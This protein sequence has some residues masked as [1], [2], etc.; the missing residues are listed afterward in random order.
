MSIHEQIIQHAIEQDI[1]ISKACKDY[2]K[3]KNY[4]HQSLGRLPVETRMLFSLYERLREVPEPYLGGDPKNVLIIGDTHAPFT[5]KGYLLHCRQ[6]Q[7]AYNCGTVVHIGDVVDNHYGSYHTTDPDGL[8]AAE[9]LEK[10]KA[11]CRIMHKMFP[12]VFAC[13]GNHDEIPFR[14]AADA[15]LSKQWIQNLTDVLGLPTWQFADEWEINNVLYTHGTGSAGEFS[16]FDKAL[17][18][19]ISVVQGHLHSAANVRYAASKSDIVFGM[20]V[21][22]GVDETSWAFAYNK[23]SKKKWVISCGVVLNNLALVVPMKL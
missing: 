15:G 1:S 10:V 7:E 16:A 2:K 4:I 9:E 17:Y 20:Q 3:G 21:G 5:R 18:R 6:V 11:D 8:S 12:N 22:C 23:Y 13:R 14:K 19:R